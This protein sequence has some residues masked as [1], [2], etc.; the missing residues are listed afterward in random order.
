M[1]PEERR[2]L[3]QQIT[4]NPLY[5]LTLD[6]LEQSAIE[7]M[8]YAPDDQSRLTA[9]LRVQ[10]VRNFRADLGE[11]LSIRAPKSAPA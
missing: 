9:A 8:I 2:S 5:D 10:A 4:T 3:A 7:A 11:A 6:G 1:T